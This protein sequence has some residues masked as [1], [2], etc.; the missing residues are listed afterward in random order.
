VGT[1][2][3]IIGIGVAV[4]FGILAVVFYFKSKREKKLQLRMKSFNLI[5]KA[6]STIVPEKVKV[7]YEDKP[8]ETM[9]VTNIAIWSAGRE[10]I[11]KSDI[12]PTE[13]LSIV[14]RGDCKILEANVVQENRPAN[15]V[16]CVQVKNNEVII[17]FEFLGKGDG[18]VIQIFHTGITNDDLQFKGEI[19][20]GSIGHETPPFTHRVFGWKYSPIAFMVVMALGVGLMAQFFSEKSRNLPIAA[21]AAVVVIVVFV[22]NGYEQLVPEMRKSAPSSLDAFGKLQ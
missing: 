20:G 18:A 6:V 7:L 4:F 11:R 17:A 22:L 9:T 3:G 1:W 14:S 16:Q 10:P 12:A 21:T 13:P 2:I 5:G 8:I 15:T 19:I